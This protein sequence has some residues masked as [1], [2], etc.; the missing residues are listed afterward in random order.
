MSE[1]A[2]TAVQKHSAPAA[3]LAGR[4]LQR[5]CER[6]NHTVAGGQRE[7]CKGGTTGRP[8]SAEMNKG[9]RTWPVSNRSLE[10]ARLYVQEHYGTTT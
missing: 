1:R 2:L 8:S 10:L 3:P 9:P 4:I 7:E 5:K 6:G